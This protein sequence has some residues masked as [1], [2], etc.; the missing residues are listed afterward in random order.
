M[1]T[2]QGQRWCTAL[3]EANFRKG[4]SL[5]ILMFALVI[6]GIGT[7]LLTFSR[8]TAAPVIFEDTMEDAPLISE[9]QTRTSDTANYYVPLAAHYATT[10]AV[11]DRMDTL[12]W[13]NSPS[14]IRNHYDNEISNINSLSNT[15]YDNY[16]Q[17]LDYRRCQV[18]ITD[19]NLEFGESSAHFNVTQDG[20]TDTWA[21]TVCRIDGSEV[22]TSTKEDKIT[23][24]LSNVRFHQMMS[25][26]VEGLNATHEKADQIEDN[27]N[28]YGTVTRTSSCYS[29]KSTAKSNAKSLSQSAAQSAIN[30]VLGNLETAAKNGYQGMGTSSGGGFFGG[31][32]DKIQDVLGKTIGYFLDW[33]WDDFANYAFVKYHNQDISEVGTPTTSTSG[34][35]CDN[36]GTCTPP[37]GG[38]CTPPCIDYKDKA[39]STKDWEIEDFTMEISFQDNDYEVLVDTGWENLNITR[40]YF[41][42]FP[43]P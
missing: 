9:S 10:Q 1:A 7:G 11:Y 35:A 20:A 21:E 8:L 40:Q 3:I 34:C 19:K 16:P 43:S 37:P 17:E 18:Q 38:T 4:Q 13:L 12:V 41:Y 15:Y 25:M 14:Q 5:Q 27:D 6:I 31:I 26:T 23:K 28:Y 29:S 36:Y 39:T 22:K 2:L 42:D 33:Q 32:L 24:N 30:T